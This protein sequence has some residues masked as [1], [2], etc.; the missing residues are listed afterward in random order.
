ML[1]PLVPLASRKNF[2]WHCSHKHWALENNKIQARIRYVLATWISSAYVFVLSF[3]FSD[4]LWCINVSLEPKGE[5]GGGGKQAAWEYNYLKFEFSKPKRYDSGWLFDSWW[6]VGWLIDWLV[7]WLFYCELLGGHGAGTQLK[8]KVRD[9]KRS[10][11]E[12][13]K[14]RME[15]KEK[16][17]REEMKHRSSVSPTKWAIKSCFGAVNLNEKFLFGP[18]IMDPNS[19]SCQK[20]DVWCE[21]IS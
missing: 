7:D 17:R 15:R 6:L 18:G 20:R 10:Y 5:G 13:D 4:L 9:L 19:F 16:R 1:P 11:S 14:R 2:S 8:A 21:K 12:D 3:S